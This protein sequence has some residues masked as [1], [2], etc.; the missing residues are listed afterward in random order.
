LEKSG[1]HNTLYVWQLSQDLQS[2]SFFKYFRD[3]CFYR[4]NLLILYSA[5]SGL[6]P[7]V[8][9]TDNIL[10]TS[11]ADSLIFRHPFVS[12]VSRLYEHEAS[13]GIHHG[14][15]AVRIRQLQQRVMIAM[16]RRYGFAFWDTICPSEFSLIPKQG[17]QL[18]RFTAGFLNRHRVLQERIVSSLDKHYTKDYSAIFSKDDNVFELYP[19]HMH[20]SDKAAIIIAARFAADILNEFGN[21]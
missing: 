17:A 7:L 5:A 15:D 21:R 6:N 10:S 13:T 16:A 2:D 20:Y 3:V 9:T 8:S 4:F 19:D 14:V 18:R 12:K 1:F 11:T